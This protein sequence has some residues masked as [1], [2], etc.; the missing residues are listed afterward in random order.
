[1]E[2]LPSAEDERG[3]PR[4]RKAGLGKEQQAVLVKCSSATA[5]AFVQSLLFLSRTC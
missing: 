5:E 3:E 1:M 2:K 4:R